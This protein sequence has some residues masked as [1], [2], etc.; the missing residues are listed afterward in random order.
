LKSS[1]SVDP[2]K[3][4]EVFVRNIRAPRKCGHINISGSRGENPE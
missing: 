4:K 2:E 1:A 3:K